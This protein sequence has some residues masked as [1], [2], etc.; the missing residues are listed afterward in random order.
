MSKKDHPV[1]NQ[2]KQESQKPTPK[3]NQNQFA[4]SPQNPAH[5]GQ[6]HQRQPRP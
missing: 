3:G 4:E 5:A 6:G 1:A 2:L